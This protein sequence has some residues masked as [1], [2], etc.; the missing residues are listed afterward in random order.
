MD[1]AALLGLPVKVTL[2]PGAKDRSLTGA[3]YAFDP[4]LSLLV[5]TN[6]SPTAPS[7]RAFH[8][9][10]TSQLV[11]LAVL[12]TVPD[13]VVLALLAQPQAVSPAAV[14]ARVKKALADEAKLKARV[15]AGVTPEAQALFD[16]LGRTLPVRWHE[17]S[18]VVMD[19]VIIAPPYG[20]SD[21]KGG[22]GTP[23]HH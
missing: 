10:K 18:I 6:P 15:G 2:A 3:V 17:Q 1:L 16:A 11:D 20:S 22:K 14:D 12:S 21:V 19:E 7:K 9:I 5:L 13:P 8:L 4:V 23:L